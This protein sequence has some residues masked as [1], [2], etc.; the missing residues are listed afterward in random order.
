MS[1]AILDARQWQ[2]TVDLKS[3]RP[4]EAEGPL[5]DLVRGLTARHP[6]PG[7]R[8]PAGNAWVV[9]TALDLIRAYEP[10]FAFVTLARQYYS[11][12]YSPMTSQERATMVAEAFAEA[13][14]FARESGFL[15]ILIGTGDMIPATTPIDLSDLDGLAVASNWST[16][17][18]GLYNVSARDLERLAAHP[19]L[20][21]VASR[22]EILKLFHGG[23]QDGVR[24]PDYMAVTRPGHYFKNTSLRRLLLITAR[25]TH[26]PVSANL[27]GVAS[28][29]DI[30]DRVLSLLPERK[31]AIVL[32]EGVGNSDFLGPYTPCRNGEGWYYY[33]PGD[34]QYL[35]IT[36]GR[37]AVFDFNG[38]YRYFRDDNENNY[39]PFSGYFTEMPTGTI[40]QD[41]PG[42][43]IAVGNRSMFMHM[44][45]GCDIC[46]E[47]FARNLYNQGIMQDIFAASHVVLNENFFSGLNWRFFQALASG[48]LLLS[49]RGG[50]GV[51]RFFREGEHYLGY[52][53]DDLLATLGHLYDHPDACNAIAARGQDLCRREHTSR[54]RVQ[55]VLEDLATGQMRPRPPLP[56]RQYGE[57]YGKYCH[58]VRFGGAFE[59]SVRLLRALAQD[60]GAIGPRAS[61]R[62]GDI[63]LRL[64]KR[65]ESIV[66]LEYGSTLVDADGLRANLK[67]LLLTLED[68]RFYRYLARLLAMLKEMGLLQQKYGVYIDR[69]KNKENM[70]YTCY[71]LGC[72]LLFA[73]QENFALG[74]EKPFE[75]KYPDYALEYARCAFGIKKT[76]K[77]LDLLL[78]CITA[79]GIAPEALGSL[80]EAIVA[81]VASDAQV[82][83]SVA[84]AV[85]YYDFAYAQTAV[86]AL[87]KTLR[88]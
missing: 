67:L 80:K 22:A 75:D 87:K 32:L 19:S 17:S 36:S 72:E 52:A 48:S 35:T 54:S 60:R 53:P 7:D 6:F 5:V 49:E 51:S 64:G 46:C 76:E 63:A 12:R 24:L 41:Y 59:E 82:A 43:S 3:G 23:P 69:L 40:G 45:T 74:F 30:K 27:E 78:Q 44:T 81:G 34:A 88:A 37:H 57:A 55:T 1:V 29:T 10:S 71:L 25:N 65:E 13:H 58:A 21:R 2:Q 79:A 38:G 26:V 18:A 56:V 66:A 8:D 11:S 73:V 20:E 9:D 39:Y 77:S 33:E 28:L 85:A 15:T 14:R 61:C 68:G 50:S 84:L 62:L 83:R 4:V 86:S 31:V 70:L 16:R 47:C 42:R